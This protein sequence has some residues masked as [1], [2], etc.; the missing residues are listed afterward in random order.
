MKTFE[1]QQ[2][3]FKKHWLE[4]KARLETGDPEAGAK[5]IKEKFD[6]DIEKE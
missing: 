6:D 1:E 5:F 3:F 2:D 4:M